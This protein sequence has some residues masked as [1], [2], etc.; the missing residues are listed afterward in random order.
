MIDAIDCK[1]IPCIKRTAA[2]ATTTTPQKGIDGL[3]MTSMKAFVGK[4]LA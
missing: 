2:A 3:D 4:Y 1:K